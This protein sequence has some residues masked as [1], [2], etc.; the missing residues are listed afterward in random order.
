LYRYFGGV[1]GDDG[2]HL[3]QLPGLFEGEA[4]LGGFMETVAGQK[5]VMIPK[6][7][8]VD[9]HFELFDVVTEQGGGISLVF[10][11]AKLVIDESGALIAGEPTPDI[12]GD[13]DQKVQLQPG[14]LES[15]RNF[16]GLSIY[17]KASGEA[18]FIL[19]DEAEAGVEQIGVVLADEGLGEVKDLIG[20][21]GI[22]GHR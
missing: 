14:G 7:I 8:A 11:M 3:L 5:E 16:G 4:E 21:F 18:G 12:E 20:Y 9:D 13:F 17:Q 10:A 6:T 15:R 19:E 22:S 2:A 1:D